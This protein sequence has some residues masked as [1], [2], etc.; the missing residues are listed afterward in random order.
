M[1]ATFCG[2]CV[3]RHWPDI[4]VNSLVQTI[5]TS[6][7]NTRKSATCFLKFSSHFLKIP[8]HMKVRKFWFQSG[9]FFKMTYLK[10][11][12]K[13][14]YQCIAEIKKKN[15]VESALEKKIFFSTMLFFPK[16][17]YFSRKLREIIFGEYDYFWGKVCVLW[18][19][20]TFFFHELGVEYFLNRLFFRKKRVFSKNS[21]YLFLGS[22]IIFEGKGV[23]HW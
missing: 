3:A 8:K 17:W 19:K 23:Y 13:V 2:N 14:I 16:N 21:K 6:C 18:Q 12:V 9:N 11:I 1:W 20:L 5:D 4:L 10:N 15:G 7:T 22:M